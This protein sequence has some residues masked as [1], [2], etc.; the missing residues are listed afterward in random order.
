MRKVREQLLETHVSKIINFHCQ[1]RIE[2]TPRITLR[3]LLF[4]QA[5]RCLGNPACT[6]SWW[7]TKSRRMPTTMYCNN[8]RCTR[9]LLPPESSIRSDQQPNKASNASYA[10]Y[11]SKIWHNNKR[12]T[13]SDSMYVCVRG[14]RVQNTESHIATL[15]TQTNGTPC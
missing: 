7:D 13:N 14:S 15:I 4:L 8:L 5:K 11:P 2:S 9:S 3:P 12:K 1:I 6:G 10:C